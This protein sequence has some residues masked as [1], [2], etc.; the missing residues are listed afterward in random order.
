M[1]YKNLFLVNID[2]SILF[3]KTRLTIIQ[4]KLFNLYCHPNTLLNIEKIVMLIFLSNIDLEY[5][6]QSAKQ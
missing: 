4:R 1:Y 5:D 3:I 2:I 6:C